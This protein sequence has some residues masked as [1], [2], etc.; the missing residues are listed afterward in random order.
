MVLLVYYYKSG[1]IQLVLVCDLLG[2]CII[3]YMVGS[4]I[5]VEAGDKVEM[6]KTG[7]SYKRVGFT[8]TF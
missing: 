8:I 5:C 3:I 2:S 4:I 1:N 6:I 7:G